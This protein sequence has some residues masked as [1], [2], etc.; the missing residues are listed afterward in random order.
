[1]ATKVMSD[2]ELRE[3]IE[4][5]LDW[6]PSIDSRHIGVAAADGVVTLTGHVSSYAQK[7]QAERAAERVRGVRGIVNEIEV[8]LG[9]E[10]DDADLAK[11]AI[12]ALR[13]NSFVPADEITVKVNKGWITLTGEVRLDYQRRAAERAVR[14]LPGV[15]GV[16]NAVVLKR[17]TAE[18]ALVK[19]EIE[20]MLT[21]QAALDA[22]NIHVEVDGDEVI[23]RGTV[24]SW[25]ER[26]DAERAAWKAP[27]VRSVQNLL[28]IDSHD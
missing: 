8:K 11:A 1:V 6:E 10:R 15:R 19:E 3:D 27:G 23:L 20:S 13:G 9:S 22:R 4:R 18:P 12:Q 16:T 25:I 21:R 2:V 28:T 7:W 24:R 26:R 5:E 17:P 14:Y